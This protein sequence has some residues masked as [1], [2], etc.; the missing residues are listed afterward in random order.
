MRVALVEDDTHVGQLMCLWLEEAGYHYQLF[1]TGTDFQKV[2]SRESFDLVIL[3]WMLPDTTGD[4][5]LIWLRERQEW[6]VPVVFVTARNSEEDIVRGLSL[7]ADDYIV[8]PVRRNELL[9]RISAVTRRTQGATDSKGSLH[10]APYEINLAT[11][12]VTVSGIPVELTQKEYE[13]V[14]FLFRNIDRLLSRGHI[15]ESVW[16]QRSDLPTR[17][18][19]THMSRIRTKLALGTDNKW[20]LNAI[21]NQGYRLE[22]PEPTPDSEQTS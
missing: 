13:L 4:Q 21:Y 17:T 1:T 19:D 22:A 3:D 7:G 11:R 5:L 6:R 12:T 16:G 14:L 15:L 2:V 20:R 18:V 8:K 10:V 9:A